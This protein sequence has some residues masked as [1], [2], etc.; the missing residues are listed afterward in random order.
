M[1]RSAILALLPVAEAIAAYFEPPRPAPPPLQVSSSVCRDFRTVFMQFQ[2]RC[3]LASQFEGPT[4][5]TIRL[6]VFDINCNLLGENGAVSSLE[7][8]F[9][10][11]SELPYVIVMER[12]W[13]A[14]PPEFGYAGMDWGGDV[15]ECWFDEDMYVCSQVFQC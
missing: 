13:N 12:F 2:S 3:T 9:N 5:T 1:K 10:L 11:D 8:H 7:P 6:R 14:T 4:P 15:R